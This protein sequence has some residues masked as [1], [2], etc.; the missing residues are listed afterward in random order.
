MKKPV[1]IL[2]VC[3]G[4]ICR[5]PLAEGVFRHMVK[6][7]GLD[8]YFE[9]DS[10]GT[11]PWHVGEPPDRRMRET[12]KR[13]GL[14]IDDL[15]GRQ[16]G[17]KDFSAYDHI[18]VM[19]RQNLHDVLFHDRKDEHG[20]KVKLFREADPNADTYEVPDPYYGGPQG[21]DEVYRMV[22][23]TAKNLLDGLVE[24]YGLEEKA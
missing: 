4:N 16:F 9:I 11:G 14:S 10:A 18:F 20:G 8:G 21:F 15:R 17:P 22:E 1:R 6:E 24:H 23:R 3:L 12:A 7:R 2:F 19:D 13:Y 5:S